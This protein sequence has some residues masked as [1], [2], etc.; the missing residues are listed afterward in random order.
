MSSVESHTGLSGDG[1]IDFTSAFLAFAVQVQVTNIGS[2]YRQMSATVPYLY[3]GLGWWQL[4]EHKGSLGS[5]PSGYVPREPYWIQFVNQEW[6]NVND[7]SYNPSGDDGFR[8]HLYPGVV[9]D[10]Y[11]RYP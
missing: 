10:F 3:K 1:E 2:N 7:Y 5:A 4:Y 11:F 6:R 9:A 8:Y